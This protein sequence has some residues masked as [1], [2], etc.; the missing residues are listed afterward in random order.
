MGA[1]RLPV[2]LGG[3]LAYSELRMF[4]FLTF[5]L[6]LVGVMLIHTGSN[7]INDYFDD[8]RG[9]DRDNPEAIYPFSGGPG[10]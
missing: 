3:V 8:K 5:F 7:F 1:S 9:V 2:V 10:C 4:N 6:S